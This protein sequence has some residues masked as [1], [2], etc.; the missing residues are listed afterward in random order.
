MSK[1]KLIK[2]ERLLSNGVVHEEYQE[3]E[4]SMFSLL[5]S[6]AARQIEK[7]VSNNKLWV[8]NGKAQKNTDFERS[9]VI[10]FVGKRGTGKTS[11]MLSFKDQLE[12][13]TKVNKYSVG[14]IKL[15]EE[16]SM[17]NV[18]FYTLDCIDVSV[19]EESENVFI[20]VLANM[21]NK[22]QKRTQGENQKIKEYDNRLIFQKFDKIYEDYISIN[23]TE[24]SM[25]GFSAYERLRNAA[26]SQRIRENFAELVKIYLNMLDSGMM[27]SFRSE[28]NYLVIALDDIDIARRKKGNGTD[29]WG[30]YKIMNVIYKYLTVPG[31]IVLTSY[32]HISLQERCIS[33]FKDEK[34]GNPGYEEAAFQYIEKIFPI[35]SRLYMPPLKR[36]EFLNEDE[37]KISVTNEGKRF[38]EGL[39]IPESILRIQKFIFRLLY[40]KTEVCFDC[41]ETNKH[42]FEPDTLRTLYNIVELLNKLETYEHTFGNEEDIERFLN[43]IEWMEEDCNFRYKEEILN[44]N[45]TES[46]LIDLWMEEPVKQRGKSIV[47]HM[48]R[49][50][51]PLG[52][53]IKKRY[54][55]EE[56][57]AIRTGRDISN[58]KKAS[59]YDNS[60]VTYSYA[61]LV[62]SIFHM[63]RN[64]KVYSKK[65]VAC[66]LYSYTL[67]LT[68]IY[69]LYIWNKRKL[70]KTQFFSVFRESNKNI[71]ENTLEIIRKINNCHQV[72][73]SVMGETI[74]GK[75]V[76]YFFPE[77]KIKSNR[78]YSEIENPE[79]GTIISYITNPHEDLRILFESSAQQEMIMLKLKRIVFLTMMYVDINQF[80]MED[81]SWN[82]DH[83]KCIFHLKCNN[84]SDFEFTAFFKHVFL[85]VDYLNTLEKWILK[86]L[87]LKEKQEKTENR[88]VIDIVKYKLQKAFDELW[89]EYYE[90]DHVYGNACIPFYSLDITYNMIKKH[91]MRYE[92]SVSQYLELSI[93]DKNTPFLMEY[94]KMLDS[95]K[96]YLNS[97]DETYGLKEDKAF[98]KIF[99]RCPFYRMVKA[100]QNDQESRTKISDY[101]CDKARMIISDMNL[102][103]Q[104]E[105]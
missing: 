63:T 91:Y 14:N 2:L 53:D 17:D 43:N 95:F 90:W 55:Q 27:N 19:L 50:I 3:F 33:F 20:L 25:E 68:E 79:G 4:N 58:L 18:K 7:I 64:E 70:S 99:E 38:F 34:D 31:V 92:Q 6:R 72:L 29:N 97:I 77:I 26:S 42:F 44:A 46:G 104:P 9:N 62:H 93:G 24:Q 88:M 85:Y 60:K 98:A 36:K 81:V 41:D 83:E 5:Y 10:S 32:D 86:S 61:E 87:V 15:F 11:A 65:F 71:D 8:E 28:Q 40:S 23:S 96:D 22:I 94:K 21:F 37:V 103:K 30:T 69:K 80:K 82:I 89:N 74:V 39:N 52:L 47:S 54:K 100:L 49:T 1:Q 105:G 102:E 12:E 35:Y 59:I 73:N 66:I 101:M 51:L 76:G 84:P 13:H 67:K 45:K 56:T 78:N 16:K 75:W 57:D 48:S